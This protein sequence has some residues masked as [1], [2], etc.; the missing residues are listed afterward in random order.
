MAALQLHKHVK[1]S[2]KSLFI[3]LFK[4]LDVNH[5]VKPLFIRLV[6]EF[7]TLETGKI[8]KMSLRRDGFKVEGVYVCDEDKRTY[9]PFTCPLRLLTEQHE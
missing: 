5:D 8:N 7:P 4:H 2:T 3:H 1:T 9:L 6:T